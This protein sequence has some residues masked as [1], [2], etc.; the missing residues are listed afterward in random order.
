MLVYVCRGGLL[1]SNRLFIPVQLMN[2]MTALTS[3]LLPSLVSKP[4]RTHFCA[5]VGRYSHVMMTTLLSKLTE[6]VF[7]NFSKWLFELFS[8]PCSFFLYFTYYLFS[9]FR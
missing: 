5:C 1:Q 8:F 2:I 4:Q 9:F 6:R 7:L 3:V